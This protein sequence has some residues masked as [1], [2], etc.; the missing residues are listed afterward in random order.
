MIREVRLGVCGSCGFLVCLAPW[1][2]L[3]CK[4]DEKDLLRVE[5]H[6]SSAVLQVSPEDPFPLSVLHRHPWSKI[7]AGSGRASSVLAVSRSIL[8]VLSATNQTHRGV[9]NTGLCFLRMS[10]TAEACS[11]LRISTA[12]CCAF[13]SDTVCCGSHG[14]LRRGKK[15]QKCKYCTEVEAGSAANGSELFLPAAELVSALVC[16]LLLCWQLKG[17]AG[18][19]GMQCSFAYPRTGRAGWA[20]VNTPGASW[21][22]WLFL[23]GLPWQGKP[24]Y[25][26]VSTYSSH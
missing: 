20:L 22:S 5:E 3:C 4:G 21:S 12:L 19:L 13:F 23:A 7:W 11:F 15:V 2:V 16:S 18:I 24:E 10:L 17:H 1:G 6:L 8:Y 25:K 26:L 14:A 9:G